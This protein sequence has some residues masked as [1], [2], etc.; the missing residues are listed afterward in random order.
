M[1]TARCDVWSDLRNKLPFRASSV[2]AFYSHH[3]IEHLPNLGFHLHE[4]YRCLKPGG[5]FRIGGPNGDSAIKKFIQ[6]D[7]EWFDDF[8][9]RWQSV[10]GRF[11]NFILCRNEHLTILTLSFL[12][13]LTSIAGFKIIKPVLPA[14]E[15]QFPHFFDSAV[16]SREWER[17]PEC[18]HTL[19]IEGQKP[20]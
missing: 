16:L 3:V 13:E 6:G 10:G 9:R 7:I 19:L 2:D 8:P 5:V 14:T 15:T 11:D 17:T 12:S 1:F 20:Q 18:P 4:L